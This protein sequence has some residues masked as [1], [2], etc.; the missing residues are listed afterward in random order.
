LGAE[1]VLLE[2]L[3]DEFDVIAWDAPG[4]GGSYDPL[5]TM[6]M[7]DYAEAVADLVGALGLGRPHLCGLSFGGGLA[8]AVY[9]R[10][11]DLAR[12]LVL[13]SAYAG[14]KG[15]LPHRTKSRLDSAECGPRS[16]SRRRSGSTA[17]FLRPSPGRWRRK[18][19][20]T[21]GRSCSKVR[22][23]GVLPMLTAFAE[24]DLTDVLPTIAVPTL[25]LYGEVDER[26]PAL[27]P[28]HS[29]PAFPDRNSW[30]CPVWATPP[31][32]KHPR[33]STPRSGASF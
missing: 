24:A 3:S 20:S 10:N 7:A 13:A 11:P 9:Q 1:V 21:P 26:A 30:C 29:T 25:L 14:W 18:Y 8:L 31:T 23:A 2:G 33:R 12:S 6:T 5:A 16:T 22:P 19:S 17:T 15:S 27:W 4:C 28:R 32:S